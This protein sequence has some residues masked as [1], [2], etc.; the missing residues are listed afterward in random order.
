MLGSNDGTEDCLL[1]GVLLGSLSQ[2]LHV[3]RHTFRAGPKLLFPAVLL[4][5]ILFIFSFS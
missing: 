5:Q 2:I 1:V 4:V 3:A